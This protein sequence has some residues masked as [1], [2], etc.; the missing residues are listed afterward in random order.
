MTTTVNAWRL[1]YDGSTPMFSAYLSGAGLTP[2]RYS[3]PLQEALAG[4]DNAL[5]ALVAA[6]LSGRAK[7]VSWRGR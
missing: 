1:G 3:M 6:A 5:E 2:G 4:T 7:L